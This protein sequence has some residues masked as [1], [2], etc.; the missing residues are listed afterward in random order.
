MISCNKVVI[1]E[2]A[3]CIISGNN[4]VTYITAL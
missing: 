2:Y 4:E 3:L 1:N